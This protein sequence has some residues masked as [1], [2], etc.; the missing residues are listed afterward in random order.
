[1]IS[2]S[3]SFCAVVGVLCLVCQSFAASQAT[4]YYRIARIDGVWWFI[5]PNGE[6]CFSSGVN[7]VSP[8]VKRDQYDPKHPAYAAFHHYPD[9]SAWGNDTQAKL[10]KWGFNTIGGWSAAEM[11]KGP[12]PYVEVL[13]LG[14]RLGVPWNDILDPEFAEKVE[15]RVAADVGPRAD[16]QHILGWC[17]DNELG[18]YPDTLFVYHLKQPPEHAT[19][20]ALVQL[21]REQYENKFDRLQADF[22]PCGI[23]SFSELEAGGELRLRPGGAGMKVV[24]RFVSMLAKRYYQTV[25][26]AI[27]R[28]DANHL[29][30][31]DRYSGYCP[32]VVAEAAGPY[33]DALSTNFDHPS[34]TDGYLPLHFLQR[35]HTL[36][37]KPVLVTEYYVAAKQNRSGNKNSGNVFTTVDTQRERATALSNRLTMLASLPYV[38]GAHWFQFAD[39][40]TDGRGDGE[41]YNFG[42]IDIHNRPYDQLTAAFARMH[43]DIPS[44]HAAVTKSA[45]KSPAI[46]RI[47][48]ARPDARAGLGNWDTQQA[49][50][51]NTVGE[52]PF[53]DLLACWDNDRLYLAVSCNRFVDAEIYAAQDLAQKSERLE[54]DISLGK[55]SPTTRVYFGIGEESPVS[56]PTVDCRL[57]SNGTRYVAL[58]EIPVDRL[59]REAFQVGDRLDLHAALADRREGTKI[60]WSCQIECGGSPRNGQTTTS[61]TGHHRNQSTD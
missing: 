37:E 19:R 15:H 18:W 9:S 10:E 13:H 43:A 40:P 45:A 3:S 33:V 36:S 48:R 7:V 27:R 1:V 31:G 59:G 8:G 26:D 58:A 14:K 47:P 41:D 29:I 52:V 11:K 25:H 54:W 39:E 50:I 53:A 5:Q 2:T 61:D 57:W 32:D 49:R 24:N 35:L 55:D 30:L 20:R 51:S 6:R 23:Q 34:W 4:S 17:T 60:T 38:V 46:V 21:L 28:H 42:L 44:I 12:M 56:E 16:D 22:R